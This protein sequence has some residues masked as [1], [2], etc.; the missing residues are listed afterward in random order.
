M[1]QLTLGAAMLSLA[2][3]S[4]YTPPPAPVATALKHQMQVIS[5]DANLRMNM[6]TALKQD[7]GIVAVTEDG[8]SPLRLLLKV[9]PY[10]R[11]A[12]A[13]APQVFG[14]LTPAPESSNV[15]VSYQLTSIGGTVLDKGEAVGVG[16]PKLK[17]YPGGKAKPDTMAYQD[18]IEQ[19]L[20]RI[21]PHIKV[22]SWRTPVVAVVDTQHILI[23]AG[24][25]SGLKVGSLLQTEALPEA[26]LEVATFE[27]MPTG[28]ERAV[29]RLIS[30][31]LPSVGKTLIPR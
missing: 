17:L 22:Q 6:L 1:K 5:N 27:R 31:T 19:I 21:A 15:V 4:S 10:T 28:T 12:S 8:L 3:C 11:S 7:Q 30:G 24:Q 29:L 20:P 9:E 18:A 26:M 16:L 23:A 25:N 2:A 14:R 13:K